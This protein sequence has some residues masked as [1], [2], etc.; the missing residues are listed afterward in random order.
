MNN[1][2]E[3]VIEDIF[4]NSIKISYKYLDQYY[5]REILYIKRRNHL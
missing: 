1:T 3:E 2:Q 4:E 5:A